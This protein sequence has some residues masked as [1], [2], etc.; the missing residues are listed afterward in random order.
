MV[1]IILIFLKIIFVRSTNL[2]NLLTNGSIRVIFYL[3]RVK[4]IKKEQKRERVKTGR[5][6]PK[7]LYSN[8]FII[9]YFL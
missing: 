8:K 4:S 5:K 1:S 6:S 9:I 3:K 7:L 2:H